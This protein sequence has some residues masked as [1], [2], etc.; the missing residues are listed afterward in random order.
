MVRIKGMKN[1]Q[2]YPYYSLNSPLDSLDHKCTGVKDYIKRESKKF[3][4]WTEVFMWWT[5]V[6]TCVDVNFEIQRVMEI[7]NFSFCKGYKMHFTSQNISFSFSPV[8]LFHIETILCAEIIARLPQ[9]SQCRYW[10]QSS[11]VQAAHGE[12]LWKSYNYSQIPNYLH[13]QRNQDL[14]LSKH[15]WS[16]QNLKS[17]HTI[18]ITGECWIFQ[19]LG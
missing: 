15:K 16:H 1:I 3:M 12:S 19:L 13:F 18:K 10:I 2:L 17:Y 5:E 8:L 11:V 9:S 4:W 7:W 14:E 6:T